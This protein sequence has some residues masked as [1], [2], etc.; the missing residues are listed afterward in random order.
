MATLPPIH[1]I[2]DMQMYQELLTVLENRS[3]A[4]TDF[5]NEALL[6]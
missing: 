5:L 3:Q 4:E 1:E 6:A 2:D